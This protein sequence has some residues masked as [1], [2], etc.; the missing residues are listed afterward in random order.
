V[1]RG[2]FGCKEGFVLNPLGHSVRAVDF[3]R[4]FRLYSR[5]RVSP[6]SRSEL[7]RWCQAGNVPFNGEPVAWDEP[8]DFPITS[9][10]IFPNGKRITLW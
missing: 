9:L 4:Q 3:L 5:E 10:V 6:V 1:P 8:I 2:G 7:Q